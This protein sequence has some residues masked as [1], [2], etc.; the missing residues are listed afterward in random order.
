MTTLA[1]PAAHAP[2]PVARHWR[3]DPKTIYLNHGSFGAVPIAVQD[4]QQRIRDLMEADGVRF[5]VQRLEGLLD[6]SRAA[7]A[8]FLKCA[9]ADLVFVPNV[10][11]AVSTILHNLDEAELIGPGDELL[12]TSH[13]YP[14][15]MNELRRHARKWGASIVPASLPFPARSADE[16]EHAILAA[17]T[18]RTKLAMLS[19]VT[20]SSGIIL[21]MKRL[22]RA[23]EGRGVRVLVDA[24]HSPGFAEGLDLDYGSDAARP[25]YYTA[26]CHKW[27]CAP[28]GTGV[29]FVRED[30]RRE[31]AASGGFRPLAL[32]NWAEK[33]KPGRSDFHKEFDY[34]GTQDFT[35]W[36]VLAD[37]IAA[38][39]A[40]AKELALPQSWAAVMRH[41]RDLCLRGRDLVCRAIGVEPSAATAHDSLLGPLATIALPERPPE[42]SARLA[43]RPSAYHDAL[44]DTLLDRHGIQVPV[45][46]VAHPSGTWPLPGNAK[47]RRVIRLSAQLYNTIDQYEHLAEALA[48]ALRAE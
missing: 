36:C 19:E 12:V 42:V 23:L 40:I 25:S 7:L 20:S 11:V 22:V 15:C 26:N 14:A 47:G 27:L 5:F 30:R 45:W 41:N 38:L 46:S 34:V 9:A 6:A 43:A 48:N 13:E 32:S 37:A 39:P 8:S 1:R 3:I 31:L 44:Q 29:L 10:T 35:S 24:A 28:K 2:S 33:P 18:P 4:A 21:P 16:L 17:V